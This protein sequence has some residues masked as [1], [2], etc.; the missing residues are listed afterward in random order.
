MKDQAYEAFKESFIRA[1]GKPFLNI[2]EI[3]KITGHS[4]EN[5]LCNIEEEKR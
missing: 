2:S 5:H 1:A 3:C 4:Y